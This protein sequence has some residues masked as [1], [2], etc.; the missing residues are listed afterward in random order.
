MG[1][2]QRAHALL[3]VERVDALGDGAQRVDVQAGVGLVEHGDLGLEHRHLEDLAALLLAAGE[4]V[5][6]VARGELAVHVAAA[7]WR[8]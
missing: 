2:D 5:V 3:G 6:E 8:A 7:R 1:D 4:A